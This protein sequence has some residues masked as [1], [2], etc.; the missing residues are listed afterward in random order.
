ML[1]FTMHHLHHIIP[2][3]AKD[4]LTWSFHSPPIREFSIVNTKEMVPM[5]IIY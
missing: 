2:S 1:L 5:D 4:L 3:Q